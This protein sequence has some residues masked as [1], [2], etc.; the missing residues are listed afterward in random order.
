MQCTVVAGVV[1]NKS[2]T[3]VTAAG[4]TT[5][6]ASYTPSV[7]FV[8]IVPRVGKVILGRPIQDGIL[9]VSTI[10]VLLWA[11]GGGGATGGG[12]FREGDFT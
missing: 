8:F 7:T 9:K 11:G 10:K 2:F 6:S 1:T 5:T 4:G 3:V 12:V